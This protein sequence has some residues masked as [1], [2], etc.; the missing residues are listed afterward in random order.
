MYER[1]LV[2][3]DGSRLA[4]MALPYAEEMAGRLGSKIILLSVAGSTEAREY[5]QHQIYV[6]KIMGEIRHNAER[7]LEKQTDK[8]IKVD[9]ATL[10][11]HPAEEIVNYAD[12]EA[13]ELI[14]MVTHGLSGIRR[15]ALGSVADK[16]VRA[17][18]QPVTLIRANAPRDVCEKGILDKLLVPLDGSSESEVV[19][20]YVEELASRLKA[21]VT[22]LQVVPQPDRVYADAEGYLGKVGDS[23]REKGITVQCEI[24]VG[25]AADEII[26][27]AD[28]TETDVVMMAAHGSSGIGRWSLGSIAEKVLQGG[29]TPVMLVRTQ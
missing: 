4:E 15:W 27:L 9:S 17:A 10:V 16:V 26:K 12:K 7:Y 13:V 19:L 14:V 25:T 2:P 8:E 11:G 1:I 28:E 24:K 22:L 5:H 6:E 21:E 23:L 18:K 29:N 3:L 20:P